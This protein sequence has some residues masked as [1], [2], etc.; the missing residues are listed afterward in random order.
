M[1]SLEQML[2]GVLSD[3]EA[4]QKIMG[5]AQSLGQDQKAPDPASPPPVDAPDLDPAALSK[6]SGLLGK[7]QIGDQ[8]QALLSALSPYIKG[9]RIQKLRRAMEAAR[10]AELAKGVLGSGMGGS[11]V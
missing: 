9:T 8:E 6:I 1:D 5:L 4:I 11:H 2:Q 7:A 3:P 10:M